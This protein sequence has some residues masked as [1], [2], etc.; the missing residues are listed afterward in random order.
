VPQAE[1]EH[2][3]LMVDGTHARSR[4]RREAA[5]GDL[6]KLRAENQASAQTL[7]LDAFH[8]IAD[9]YHYAILELCTCEDFEPRAEWVAERLGITANETEL[10]LERL[11]RLGLLEI[12]KGRWKTRDDVTL[13]P[14][15]VPSEASSLMRPRRV[16]YGMSAN[17]SRSH[18]SGVLAGLL[19]MA[20]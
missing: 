17:A 2:F 4:A 8:L 3:V 5:A 10:A 12:T 15:G 19:T 6:A 11:Q 1:R 16:L 20:S 7:G 18:R 13:S 9:W 14:A